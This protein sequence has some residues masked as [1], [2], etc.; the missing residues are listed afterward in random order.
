M[1]K[2][3]LFSIT[4]KDFD[5]QTFCSG[6]PGGQHQNKTASGVR[7]IHRASG[8]VGESRTDRSQHRNKKLALKRLTENPKFKLWIARTAFAVTS[9]KTI[10]Q[11]VEESINIKNLKLEGKDEKDRWCSLCDNDKQDENI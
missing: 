2:E 11:R 9:G 6:G 8:A 3:L 1:K 4:K 5:V 7:I 10:E